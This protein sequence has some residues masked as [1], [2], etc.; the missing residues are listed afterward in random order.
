MGS[1]WKELAVRSGGELPVMGGM[2][3]ERGKQPWS[4]HCVITAQVGSELGDTGPNPVLESKEPEQL[5]ALGLFQWEP[6]LGTPSPCWVRLAL[7]QLTIS[8]KEG[9]LAPADPAADPGEGSL[10]GT[11][12]LWRDMTLPWAAVALRAGQCSCQSPLACHVGRTSLC[13]GPPV[14]PRPCP[15]A[16]MVWG[17]FLGQDCACDGHLAADAISC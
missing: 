1:F 2:H 16:S 4:W 13:R 9:P 14:H 7:P 8:N 12:P 15:C 17:G 3:L 10:T 6:C 5:R 11:L